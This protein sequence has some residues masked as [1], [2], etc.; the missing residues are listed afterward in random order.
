VHIDCDKPVPRMYTFDRELSTFL[1]P[2][3]SRWGRRSATVS[4]LT[5]V[6]RRAT[7][8]WCVATRTA[9]RPGR[10]TGRRLVL[11]LRAARRRSVLLLLLTTVSALLLAVSLLLLAELLLAGDLGRTLLV[12]SVVAGVDG[13]ENELQ[14]PKIRGEVNGWVGTSHLRG[15]VLVVGCAVHHASDG[16]VVVDL[17]Q[18][19]SGW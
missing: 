5:R 4:L 10:T 14:D 6:T 16:R 12:L 1:M 9:L 13:A 11:L 18:E 7:R 3:V 17:T 2:L 15:L 8:R 19:F